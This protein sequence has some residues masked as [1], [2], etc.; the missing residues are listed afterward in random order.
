[1]SQSEHP[2]LKK[3]LLGTTCYRHRREVMFENATHIILQHFSHPEYL[4]GWKLCRMV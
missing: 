4:G 1:M 3:W 2:V